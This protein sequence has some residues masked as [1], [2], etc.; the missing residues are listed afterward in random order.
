[1]NKSKSFLT[2]SI[3]TLI[4]T[5]I[6][7]AVTYAWFSWSTT[8]ENET[9]IVTNMG[10]A[11]VYFNSGANITSAKLRPTIEKEDG[12]VKNI[13]VKTSKDTAYKISFN[14]YLD[15]ISIDD[16]LKD[17]TFKYALYKVGTADAVAE[18]NFSQNSLNSNL[19]TCTTNNTS[20][21]VL[22]SDEAIT[23]TKQEYK[24]YIW[25]D[26]TVDNP[27]TMENQKF[28][29]K[30]HADGQ[31]AT[32]GETLVQHITKLYTPNDTVENNQ[33]T[34]NLDTTHSLINDRFGT[35][36]VGLD[37]GNIRFYGPSPNNYI[38]IGDVYTEDTIIDNM[39]K[40][41]LII[42]FF[43]NNGLSITDTDSCYKQLDCDINY[44]NLGES[45]GGA[46][47]D[48]TQCKN[49]LNYDID[50]MCGTVTINAG[51]PRLYRIIGLF[52]DMKLSDGTKQDL[53]KVMRNDSI[54][55]FA[56]DLTA[57]QNGLA[58]NNW[59]DSTLMSI[60]KNKFLLN[61]SN[62]SHY[63]LVIY[64]GATMSKTADFTE[65]GLNSLQNKIESV[66][67]NLGNIS[68]TSLSPGEMYQGE[69]DECSNCAYESEWT[70]KIA[71]AYPS[72]H[73]YGANLKECSANSMQCISANWMTTWTNGSAYE[74][75]LNPN[76]SRTD[77]AWAKSTGYVSPANTVRF[78]FGVRPTFYL[79]PSLG[80]VSG[81]G[82][83][84]NPYVVR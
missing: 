84:G 44:V 3:I 27:E 67:W 31:N 49:F 71:L 6:A 54:G 12:I 78:G 39:D 35:A 82:S 74:W 53:V 30:L 10:A 36:D 37:S 72:D 48:A 60:L 5:V 47:E 14:L 22:V 15:V 50:D 1:M 55:Y 80:I 32:A 38:D 7:S 29:F 18:G 73:F 46:F 83:E 76:V 61:S 4:I 23:T 51:T 16:G 34:Y 25:I 28:S 13:T 52:K 33:I 58:D 21:I 45:M 69:R 77:Y 59:H 40:N 63:Y 56:W 43:K 75:L 64:S 66:V 20:H 70:G 62:F 81:D 79:D 68:S 65:I 24:L 2:I 19:V 17:T 9:R 11:K 26:G 8:S 41:S 57:E 42:N